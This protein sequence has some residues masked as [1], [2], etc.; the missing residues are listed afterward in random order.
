MNVFA[1]EIGIGKD[2]DNC[3]KRFNIKVS[4]TIN[5]SDEGYSEIKDIAAELVRTLKKWPLS[6]SAAIT[7][8]HETERQVMDS[9]ITTTQDQG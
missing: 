8:L 4:R 7:V 5:L 2:N 3:M 9:K 1:T 6:I